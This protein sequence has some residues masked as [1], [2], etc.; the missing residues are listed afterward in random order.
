MYINVMLLKE[1]NLNYLQISVLNAVGM[2][3]GTLF[4][5][6]W[7]KLGDKYGFQYFL[8]LCLWIH[9]TIILLWALI[10]NSFLY[11]FFL[12]VLIDV[13]VVAGTIQLI[14][15]T[16]MYNAPQSLRSEAFSVF[17]SLSNISLFLGA[18][19]S[20]I[21]VSGFE[22]MNLPFGISSIRLAMLISFL[23]RIWSA[24]RISRV[25]FGTP[26]ETTLVQIVKESF[27]TVVVLWL[28]DKLNTLNIFKRK[29]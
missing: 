9:A 10:P 6:F 1:I 21:I 3:V 20:R 7:G 8:K 13:F 24:F 23:L 11:I 16:L 26:K 19:V 22:N 5:P 15:Y 14:F 25:D 18:L 29:R 2:F 12:Q 17:N 27:F 28:K 4:Q